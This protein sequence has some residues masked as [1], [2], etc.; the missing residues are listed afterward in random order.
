MSV[1]HVETVDQYRE[2][3]ATKGKLVCFCHISFIF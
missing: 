1:V 2:L 3:V